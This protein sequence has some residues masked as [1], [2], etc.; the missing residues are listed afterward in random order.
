MEVTMYVGRTRPLIHNGM[1]IEK[2][3]FVL[4]GKGSLKSRV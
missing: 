2:I 4:E 1:L 3:C